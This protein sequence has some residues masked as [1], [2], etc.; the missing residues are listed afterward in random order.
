MKGIEIAFRGITP[1]LATNQLVCSGSDVVITDP[2]ISEI[3][4]YEDAEATS[5]IYR[6]AT[7]TIENIQTDSTFYVRNEQQTYP[8]EMVKVEL[9]IA[10][11][12]ADFQVYDDL[13]TTNAEMRALAVNNSIATDIT[14]LVR[15]ENVGTS[16]SLYFNLQGFTSGDLQL[17]AVNDFG[18]TD[19]LTFNQTQSESPVFDD[20]FLCQGQSVT[21]KAS[22]TS[23]LYFLLMRHSVNF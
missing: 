21:F 15:G 7:F 8:S 17:V 12:K 18:C 14:W 13:S 1:D 5:L 23:A 22:N 4:V 11:I 10:E 2:A 19:T 9:T 16:D 20:Y 3:S 6:G